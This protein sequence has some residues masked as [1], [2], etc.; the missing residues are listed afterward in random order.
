MISLSA[1]QIKVTN[2][3]N[4]NCPHCYY[5]EE[6]EKGTD[7]DEYIDID[8]VDKLFDGHLDIKYI[9]TLNFSGGEPLLAEDD[10]IYILNKILAKKIPVLFIDIATNGTVLSERFAEELNYFAKKNYDFLKNHKDEYVRNYVGQY[11]D[12]GRK[13][14]TQFRISDCFHENDPQKAYEFY[15]KLMP[16][17]YV[18][19][20]K[21]R[22][23]LNLDKI[24]FGGRAKTLKNQK[25]YCFDTHHKI[26]FKDKNTIECPL[27]LYPDGI[28]TICA[29]V[30][31]K[32]YKKDIIGTVFDKRTL[33][34]M[35]T[36]WNYKVPLTCHEIRL[37]ESCRATKELGVDYLKMVNPDRHFTQ[38]EIDESC[39]N[40]EKKMELVEKTRL[41]IHEEFPELSPEEI[42][43][44]SNIIFGEENVGD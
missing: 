20:E 22:T 21:S 42:E 43:N 33:E 5:Y 39:E 28:I 1:L 30:S 10:I 26:V 23:D 16:N 6:G 25:F 8:V 14:G 3:C 44:V 31:R 41:Q 24:A 13:Y 17:V 18:E 35:I 9:H 29:Y 7:Y 27:M 11:K 37:L 38:K 34:E 2:K 4:L 15:E 32:H 36:E 12:A 40:M 19:E